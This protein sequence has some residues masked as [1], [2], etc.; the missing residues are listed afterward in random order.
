MK[1]QPA[2][3]TAA[4]DLAA[5]LTA[6]STVRTPVHT[7]YAH[8]A[9]GGSY[10]VGECGCAPFWLD[11]KSAVIVCACGAAYVRAVVL[12]RPTWTCADCGSHWG[13][14][15][16]AE[17]ESQWQGP[18]RPQAAPKLRPRRQVPRWRPGV[19]NKILTEE[20]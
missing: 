5:K 19:L 9:H 20:G 14:W 2:S 1:A 13:T 12:A 6:A 4:A 11:D 8:A 17:P 16:P 10:A 7:P 18:V 3:M 15:E